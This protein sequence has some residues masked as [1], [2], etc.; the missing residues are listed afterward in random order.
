MDVIS[1]WIYWHFIKHDLGFAEE[2]FKDDS[3]NEGMMTL[4]LWD[5]EKTTWKQ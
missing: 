5:T 3:N 2:Y 4:D 1:E